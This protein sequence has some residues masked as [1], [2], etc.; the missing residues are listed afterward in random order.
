M[1]YLLDV[2][3]PESYVIRIIIERGKEKYY[4]MPVEV[5]GQTSTILRRRVPAMQFYEGHEMLKQIIL[6]R[7]AR[8]KI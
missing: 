2:L 8:L 1:F 5:H 3:I 7:K 6:E 4:C